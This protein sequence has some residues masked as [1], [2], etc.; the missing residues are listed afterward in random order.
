MKYNHIIVFII[1]SILFSCTNSRTQVE[2][3]EET[4][5][6]STDLKVDHVN[7]WVK[8]PQLAKNLLV[9]IG[10]TSVPDS[11]S[12]IHNGQGT[13]GRYFN[14]LNG[15]LELIFIH[16]Q[17]EFNKNNQINHNLDFNER[18]DFM[19]N[20]ASPFGIALKIKDYDIEK[21]PFEK[22]RYRQDWMGEKASIYSAKNSKV[23]IK[24][25]SIFVVYPEIEADVF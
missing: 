13:S 23:N 21:I 16:N 24:E 25:P 22:V 19:A 8:N 12:K 17:E 20:G 14:F 9:D 18:A 3:S 15:Y 11:L 10:F 2:S 6:V 1:L 7:I 4:T 5:S